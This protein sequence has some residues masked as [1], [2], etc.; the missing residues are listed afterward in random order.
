VADRNGELLGHP[1][2]L[3]IEDDL[4]SGEGGTTTGLKIVADPQM[5]AILG[6][7]CSGAAVTEAKIMAEAGL[8]MIAGANTAPSLTAIG[9]QRGPDW[10]P[11]Y[12]RTSHNDALQGRAA[13]TFVF[14]ELGVK[15]AAT[16]NDGD[17]YT[18]GLT[19]VFRQV[20]TELGG[21]IVL[22]AA[23]NKGDTNMKPVLEAVA[24]SGAELVFF[25][26]FEP[27]G[28]FITLQ[29]REG[30]G[31]ENIILMGSE[32]LITS[33]FIKAVGAA[34]IG[35]YFVGPH[36]PGGSAYDAFIANYKSKYAEEPTSSNHASAYDA[37]NLLLK[38]I[39][40][41]A[42]QDTN[43]AGT[44]HLGRQALRDALYAISGFQGLTGR[45]SCD[46]FGDCGAANFKLMRLD[47]PAAG[48][49]GLAKNIVYTY[50][51]G[52]QPK[53]Q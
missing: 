47:N 39:E 4:C 1:I 52:E 41:V 6:T 27:E 36:T 43:V 50:T 44:L 46:K 22:D 10:Q 34:G 49:E 18:R 7:S 15:K 45:L 9:G 35:L 38:T 2:Q 32:G 26:L 23:I 42:I 25:P 51:P 37:A 21:E 13:A 11:G 20:F 5:V 33:T 14:E 3:Q 16:I 12:F 53:R 29:A 30:K 8:V 17:T 28:N 40:A 19:G 31:F 48:L 24:A